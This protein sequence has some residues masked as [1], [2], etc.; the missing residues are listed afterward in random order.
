VPPMDFRVGGTSVKATKAISQVLTQPAGVDN[1]APTALAVS[2]ATTGVPDRALPAASHGMIVDR[3]F[4]AMDGTALDPTTL[5]Q[6]ASFIMVISGRAT[7]S[8]PHRVVVD[9]GLPAGWELSGNISGGTVTGATMGW[10]G[11]LSEPRVRAA[12]DD[13]YEAAFDLAPPDSSYFGDDNGVDREFR[14][15]VMVRAVTPGHF[16]LPGVTLSDMFHPMVFGRT[17][18]GSVTVLAPGEAPPPPALKPTPVSVPG[19]RDPTNLKSA[20]AALVKQYNAL[21]QSLAPGEQSLLR[22]GETEW[23][24]HKRATCGRQAVAMQTVTGLACLIDQT[25]QRTKALR[26][27]ASLGH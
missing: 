26:R 5:K 20:N 7:D 13:R 19:S 1:L 11:T 6:N 27:D 23:I 9:A 3:E 10:L 16:T 18:G 12:S 17:V 25:N 24:I 21:M 15:A 8:A 22:R 4:Y 2:V 14:I